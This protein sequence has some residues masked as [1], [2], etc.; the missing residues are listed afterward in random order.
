[1]SCT[2]HDTSSTEAPGGDP[3]EHTTGGVPVSEKVT[4][5]FEVSAIK[6]A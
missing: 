5:E 6:N 3:G 2:L 4:L 1:M